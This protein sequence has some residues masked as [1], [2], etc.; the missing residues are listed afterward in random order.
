MAGE[1][2]ALQLNGSEEPTTME[3]VKPSMQNF[4]EPQVAAERPPAT[5]NDTNVSKI[6]AVSI[7]PEGSILTGKQ[8]HCQC[9]AC[10]ELFRVH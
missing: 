7:P 3:R 4:G 6:S 5:R 1:V 8:E 2:P 9:R 10:A